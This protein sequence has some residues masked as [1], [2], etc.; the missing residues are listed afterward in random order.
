M[1]KAYMQYL[2][3]IGVALFVTP[4]PSLANQPQLNK[5][6]PVRHPPEHKPIPVEKPARFLNDEPYMS[7]PFYDEKPPKGEKHTQENARVLLKDEPLKTSPFYGEKPPNSEGKKPPH[8]HEPA[9]RLLLKDEPLKSS[10]FY[11]EKPQIEREPARLLNDEP[12]LSPFD[13][14]KPPREHETARV[15]LTNGEPHESPY[16]GERPQERKPAVQRPNKPSNRRLL[17]GDIEGMHECLKTP[18]DKCPSKCKGSGTQ[19]SDE[20]EAARVLVDE[21]PYMTSPF[22]DEK[23]SVMKPPKPKGEKPPRP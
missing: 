17:G 12:R 7:S 14:E 3:L 10:P 1:S 6:L 15:L 20:H 5:P 21:E 13:G 23:T 9:T 18:G 2:F 19:P 16:F 4:T 11:G 22:Y 8:E